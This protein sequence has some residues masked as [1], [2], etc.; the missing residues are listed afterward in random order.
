MHMFSETRFKTLTYTSYIFKACTVNISK[1]I[2]NTNIPS[3]INIQITI[4]TYKTFYS[5]L[6]VFSVFSDDG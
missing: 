4:K 3:I 1:W 6:E 5:S 2:N